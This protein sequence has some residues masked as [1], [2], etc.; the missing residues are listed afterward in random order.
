MMG[1]VVR[2]GEAAG[3]HFIKG[4]GAGGR[5]P[6]RRQLGACFGTGVP[7]TRQAVIVRYYY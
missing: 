5:E 4:L 1:V 6:H 7:E 3:G 2:D